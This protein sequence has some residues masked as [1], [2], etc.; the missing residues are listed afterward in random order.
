MRQMNN[1]FSAIALKIASPEVIKDWS[2]GEVLKPETINYRTQ[3]PELD[4]L[5]CERIFGPS[6]NYECYCGKYKRIRYKGII[7]TKC[8]VEVTKSLVR[9]ERMGH[10]DLCVPV[11]HTWFVRSTPS[12]IGLA[13]DMPVKVLEQIL[14]FSSYVITNIDESEKEIAFSELIKQSKAAKKQLQEEFSKSES[15]IKLEIRDG[16][17]SSSALEKSEKEFSEKLSE[18]QDATK[19]AEK[20]LEKVEVG[21]VISEIEFRSLSMKF[22]HIFKAGTG[23]E[24]IKVL[25]ESINIEELINSLYK[26]KE[27]TTGQ[28]QVK[29]NKKIQFFELLQKSK[30]RPEWM[31][32]TTLVVIPP[33]LRPMVQLDG[34]RFAASDLN[35]LYRRIINRNN[36]LKRLMSIGAPE[37]ICRNEKRMLQEAVDT[38]LNNSPKAGRIAFSTDKRKLKSL[39]DMLK[40]KQGRFRQNLLGKRV[41]YSGRSVI[42]VGPQLKLHQCGLPKKMAL[43]LFKPF[44]IGALIKNDYTHN[45]KGAEKI[46]ESNDKIVWDFLEEITKSK[47]VLLNR[48]PTLHRLGIQAFSPVLIEGRAIQIHPLV[49]SAYNADFDGDQMAVHLPLSDEAQNEAK[50][51]ILSTTN[52]LKPS[53]GDPI[54]TPTQDIILGVYFLTKIHEGKKGEGK[55]FNSIIEAKYAYDTG[56]LDIQAKIS[57]RI[58]GNIIDD[59]SLGRAIFNSIMP[60]VIPYRNTVFNSKLVESLFIEIFE[61]VSSE[62]VVEF[63]DSI[64]DLGFKYSTKS[65]LS[66]SSSDMIVP[67]T[68]EKILEESSSKVSKITNFYDKGL[69]TEI[70]RYNHSIKIWSEAKTRIS[71]DMVANF[72][73]FPM[74]HIQ[75]MVDSGARGS[76]GQVTQLCGMKGLVANPGGKTIELPIKSNLKGGFSIVEYF[77]ATHG[78]RKGKSDTALKTAEAGYL[79]RRLVDSVQDIIIRSDDCGNNESYLITEED[80]KSIGVSFEK[81]LFGRYSSRPIATSDGEILVEAGLEIDR[82]VLNIIKEN[83][84]TEVSIRSILDCSIESG[85]CKKCYGRDLGNNEK[86]DYGTPVGIIAAQSIGEPGTQLTMRTFH[87]GGVADTGADITQGLTRV[88]ELFEARNPK[89]AAILS[90]IDGKVRFKYSDDNSKV[91]IFIESQEKGSDTYFISPTLKIMVKVGEYLKAG[92]IIAKGTSIIRVNYAGTVESIDNDHVVISHEE[93]ATISYTFHSTEIF[94]VN[95]GD[96]IKSGDPITIGHFNLQ[97]LL[98]RTNFSVVQRYITR[99]VQEIYASQGQSIHD[100]HMEVI[101]RE[102]FSRVRVLD[103]GDF[104]E[105]V[106]G[107][108]TDYYKVLSFIKNNP[109][110]K[111]PVYERM[112]LGLTRSSLTTN[113]WLSASSFQETIRVLVDAATTAKVD[114]LKGL[115]EN[116]IIGKL[117]PAGETF[118]KTMNK[119]N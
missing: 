55:V 29:I 18:L 38:L 115:K 99:E 27:L 78:G 76:W 11:A 34:G 22:G 4:G 47:Y 3:R 6:K 28:K 92:K 94:T 69:L 103:K 65:G 79:T 52:L 91:T 97:E 36:R 54:I 84:I 66:I 71:K 70:E 93:K 59:T 102:M 23:A 21:S 33:E 118:K 61:K 24:S 100:K 104:K 57:I 32:I 90:E 110:K 35:D 42:V 85:V 105:L 89:T 81:R 30:I 77:I 72:K 56:F 49:C 75:Y 46:I 58:N 101:V 31:L 88:E 41:D 114:R 25:L 73:K 12:R 67:S 112:L 109:D 106:N 43:K 17:L 50:K 60:T 37:V 45:V 86:V 68:R 119:K 48:A 40:G 14:Y 26:E 98:K 16:T 10:I 108:I 5:F 82:D 19:H 107:E 53:S 20:E 83:N 113:S 15:K 111:P 64:K 9:R 80:S 63:A 8:G 44:V 13:L 87:M 39:S 116:V 96:L 62:E 95:D 7:C 51:L 1:D 74:N 117:I 2:Y